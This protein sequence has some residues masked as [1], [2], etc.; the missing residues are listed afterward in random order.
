M[1]CNKCGKEI[2]E[3][4]VFCN[5]CG[6]EILLEIKSKKIKL[7][8]QIHIES[9][10]DY[11][12]TCDYCG[13]EFNTKSESDDHEKSCNINPINSKNICSNC[14]IE[15]QIEASFCKKCGSKIIKSNGDDSTILP[16]NTKNSKTKNNSTH[17]FLW[18]LIDQEEL[19]SQVKGYRNLGILHSSRKIAAMCLLFSS[20]VTSLLVVFVSYDSS[21]L[22]DVALMLF[23]AFFIY[24]GHRWAMIIAM[25]YWTF[26]K[27]YGIFTSYNT[28]NYVNWFV[29]LIW[30]STY[31]HV[32]Y[33]SFKVEQLRRK[34]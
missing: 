27:I 23:V 12:W 6:N 20:V 32:F 15:N 3:S 14:G 31:M 7:N 26:A 2:I 10:K 22:V 17:W 33:E 1:Y 29:P 9:T 34:K 19:N 4:S 13:K 21:S 18:W 30:W 16:V 5:F 24:R 25:L 8:E 11:I 28:N